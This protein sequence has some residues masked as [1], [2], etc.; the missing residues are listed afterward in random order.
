MSA[1]TDQGAI[2]R[3]NS[4]VKIIGHSAAWC[5]VKRHD[6]NKLDWFVA[7]GKHPSRSE[8]SD[9]LLREQAPD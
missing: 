4:I 8:P 6:K 5:L 7:G 2:P 9:N 1:Q 3:A